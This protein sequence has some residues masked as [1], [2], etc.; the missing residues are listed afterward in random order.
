MWDLEK[1]IPDPDPGV[2]NHRIPAPQHCTCLQK[3]Q[4]SILKLGREKPRD[5]LVQLW[6]C[7][8]F[9]QCNKKRAEKQGAVCFYSVT[10]CA[11]KQGAVC[12]YSVTNRA[13]KQGAV[14]FYSV[15]KR[16]EKHMGPE[17]LELYCFDVAAL[18]SKGK[19]KL[20][21]KTSKKDKKTE[22]DLHLHTNLIITN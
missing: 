18:N 12:F 7:C 21:T 20:R 17:D 10:K 4:G 22:K 15:T 5:D 19:K 16:A 9:L 8:L 3:V 14:C 1:L 2:K 11:E 13:E 6:W